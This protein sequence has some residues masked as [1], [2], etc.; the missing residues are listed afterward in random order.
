MSRRADSVVE[1][2]GDESEREQAPREV[3]VLRQ[4]EHGIADARQVASAEREVVHGRSELCPPLLRVE[5]DRE[6]LD[7]HVVDGELPVDVAAG[8]ADRPRAAS[9][10]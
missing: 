3:D 10:R 4:E 7:R 8:R 5:L 9:P 1:R 2:L 6:A